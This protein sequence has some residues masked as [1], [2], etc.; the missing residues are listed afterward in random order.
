MTISTVKVRP[1]STNFMLFDLTMFFMLKF[2]L[3]DKITE[4]KSITFTYLVFI[5]TAIVVSFVYILLNS[6]FTRL[7]ENKV[8]KCA[9]YIEQYDCKIFR[10]NYVTYILKLDKDNC[11]IYMNEM[12]L[13]LTLYDE[14]RREYVAKLK[15]RFAN[16]NKIDLVNIYLYKYVDIVLMSILL[17]IVWQIGNVITVGNNIL[18][19]LLTILVI[20]LVAI[21]IYYAVVKIF[22][23]FITRIMKKRDLMFFA[24]K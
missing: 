23:R 15:T 8:M 7:I 14:D 1:F 6:C 20:A 19:E 3:L 21:A 16:L 18:L 22:L 12:F 17:F 9:S 13:F 24:L 10:S 11:D 5:I 2:V 4:D